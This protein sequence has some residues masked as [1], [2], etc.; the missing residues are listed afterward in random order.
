MNLS[1]RY[2]GVHGRLSAMENK[3][4]AA[5]AIRDASPEEIEKMGE[6]LGRSSE[7]VMAM[8]KQ[9]RKMTDEEAALLSSVHDTWPKS[10]E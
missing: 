8:G 7:T 10:K 4:H 1:L 6:V 3:K 9:P 5:E 2:K